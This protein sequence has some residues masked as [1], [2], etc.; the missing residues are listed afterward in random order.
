MLRATMRNRVQRTDSHP[1]IH[2]VWPAKSESVQWP[3]PDRP[4]RGAATAI[5]GLSSRQFGVFEEVP[6][7]EKAFGFARYAR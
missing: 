1:A 5:L 2:S 6:T 4:D 7:T 3:T